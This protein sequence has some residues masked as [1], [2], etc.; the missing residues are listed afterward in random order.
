[1]QMVS[2]HLHE[3]SCLER[4]GHSMQIQVCGGVYGQHSVLENGIEGHRVVEGNMRKG[5]TVTCTEWSSM[6][7]GMH[8]IY[9]YL[10]YVLETYTNGRDSV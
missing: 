7:K 6:R 8:N 5:K 4:S 1:M 10:W 3:Q 9:I 2:K